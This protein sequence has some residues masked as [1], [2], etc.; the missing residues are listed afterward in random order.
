MICLASRSPRRAQLL[1]QI[2]VEYWIS[3]ADIDETPAPQEPPYDYVKRMAFEKAL[4]L[5]SSTEDVVLGA[6]TCVVID[7]DIL[8][9]PADDADAVAMLQ[10]LS[11]RSHQ[12]MSG[13]ALA[14]QGANGKVHS[15][16]LVVSTQVSFAALS[17]E[18]IRAYVATQEPAD[19]A[20]AYGIQG[21]GAVLVESLQGS[22]SNVVG[23]PL[24]ETAQLLQRWHVDIWQCK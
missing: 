4:A 24:H 7:Q 13:V 23:L 20:G 19:K 9:K 2:G 3:A 10:R 22:H 8:G 14:Q 21:L 18:Q 17:D 5:V 11:G 1:S 16:V 15:E 12:V 6:D